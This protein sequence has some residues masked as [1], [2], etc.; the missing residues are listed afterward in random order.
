MALASLHLGLGAPEQGLAVLGEVLPQVYEHCD[1][2]VQADANL[3][4]ARCLLMMGEPDA[5]RDVSAVGALQRC[6]LTDVFGAGLHVPRTRRR[7]PRASA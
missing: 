5:L 6:A 3:C 2:E 1:E 4:Y 7:V